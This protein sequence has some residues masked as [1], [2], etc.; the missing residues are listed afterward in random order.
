MDPPS[1]FAAQSSR[2]AG[3]R[4]AVYA[5]RRGVPGPL[6]RRP[7]TTLPGRVLHVTRDLRRASGAD[8]RA[9]LALRR[10]RRRDLGAGRLRARAVARESLIVVRGRGRQGPRVLQR[11]PPP[12][13]APVRS[14]PAASRAASSARTTPGP[15]ASTARCS[16]RPHMADVP[17]STRPIS[18]S[19]RRRSRN[20]K[21]SSSS[22]SRAEPEPSRRAVAAAR[23]VRALAA[24]ARS[25]ARSID[26]DVPP[27]GSSSSRTTRSATTAR[28]ST[29]RS[30][31]SR[32][33]AAARTTSRRRGPRR[34]HGDQRRAAA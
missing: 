8:L 21:A 24:A 6:P 10:P 11:L 14:R 7:R 34:L 9:A 31:S 23:A 5:A 29:R 2:L 17:G 3:R 33:T 1:R 13:H 22:T 19:S 12:R 15:T 18:R 4:P 32:T 20:G 16:A 28:P 26:Y 30:R 25:T 27:T